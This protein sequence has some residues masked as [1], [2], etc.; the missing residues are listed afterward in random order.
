MTEDLETQ[1]NPYAW[2]EVSSLSP[3][4]TKTVELLVLTYDSFRTCSSSRNQLVSGSA[5]RLRK[6]AMST[7]TPETS[8]LK[9]KTTRRRAATALLSR[10]ATI[11]LIWRPSARE[12]SCPHSTSS[13]AATS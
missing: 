8:R 7:R 13:F 5:M 9:S 6:L 4:G 1:L 10:I 12:C 11:R 3:P 2:N